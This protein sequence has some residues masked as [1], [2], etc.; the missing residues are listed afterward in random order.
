MRNIIHIHMHLRP[1]NL[2]ASFYNMFSI[3]RPE[4]YNKKHLH[5][6]LTSKLPLCKDLSYHAQPDPNFEVL[7]FAPSLSTAVHPLYFLHAL[8]AQ[9]KIM[10]LSCAT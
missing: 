3:I 2:F 8:Y 9:S 5:G 7:H 4:H 1:H 6:Y 10:K